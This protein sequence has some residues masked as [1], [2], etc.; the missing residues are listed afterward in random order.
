[1]NL[2]FPQFSASLSPNKHL[3]S[4]NLVRVARSHWQRLKQVWQQ[5]PNYSRQPRRLAVLV[6][7]ASITLGVSATAY[8][9]YSIVCGLILENL[10]DN[11][12]LRV[13][14]GTQEIDEWLATRKADVEGLASTPTFRTM[15]WSV[16]GPYLK[17]QAKRL[18]DFYDFSMINLDGSYYNTSIGRASRK[19]NDREHIK[20]AIAGSVYVSDPVISRSLGIPIVVIAVPV[21]LEFPPTEKPIGV[22]TGIISIDHIVKVVSNLKYGQGSYAFALNSEG[23]PIIHPNP[24]LMG[25]AEKPATSFLE[26]S[27]P[28]LQQ[29]ARY[30]VNGQR[31]IELVTLEGQSVYVAYSHLN[32]ADWSVALVIPRQNLEK[33]LEA[34]NL[35]AL[36]VGMLLAV[37]IAAAVRLVLASEGR[38][39][40]AER[41]A[42]LNRLTQQIRA[43]L[44][45]DCILAATVE[46]LAVLLKLKRAAFGWYDSQQQSLDI[47]WDYSS[48]HGKSSKI[49]RFSLPDKGWVQLQKGE[50]ISLKSLD[51]AKALKLKA[52]CYLA[53]S[54]L[55]PTGDSGYLICVHSTPIFDR[56][57]E[58][59]L[60]QAVADQLA[61]AITQSHLYRQTQAQVGLLANT[62]QELKT[63]QVELIH[64][65]KMSS[66]GQMVAGIAHEL[67]NPANF[68][69]GNL[70][71]V[72]EYSHTLLN[73]VNFYSECYPEPLPEIQEQIEACELDYLQTDL[74]KI[75]KSMYQG[76][77]RIRH[78]VLSLRNF[79]R[80]DESDKKT[81]DLIE[82]LENTL[83]FLQNQL[84][85]EN[86][87][88]VV[89]EYGEIP[90]IECYPGKLNQVF[91]NI[92]TNAID[93]LNE[94]EGSPKVIT[95][96]TE[97]IATP[98]GNAIRVAIADNGSGIP[99]EIQ[100]KIYDPFFTTK[101]VGKGTGLGLAISYQIITQLHQG[102]IYIQ[103]PAGGGTEFAIELPAR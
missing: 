10:Q 45:L 1:M 76:T 81:V 75:L 53:I 58:W 51:T 13:Q 35:L 96:K 32:N 21:W 84:N 19:L 31:G 25:T 38:R 91:L 7:I 85:N 48:G 33:E 63:T 94:S 54:I 52:G 65:E 99:P 5:H 83:L 90:E 86:Q 61:I 3:T 15:D 39:A 57:E 23:E 70:K 101:P 67:N 30:M 9:S 49:Q 20:Q 43:S 78:I 17:S 8:I 69:H 44:D 98:E 103:T 82:G 68:I 89:K 22:C 95:I 79:S 36:V 87:I 28:E 102:N 80:L 29:I 59:E 64:S 12:L 93:A 46:E 42:L 62:L 92:L 100:S 27:D 41:E 72:E 4:K 71:Y 73:I 14:Q 55:L 74:R 6:A 18:K 47:Q 37:A 2:Q 77:E 60:L 40:R 66:L 50:T 88:S 26:A 11:T 34:L 97:A 16:V 24:K 56:Q